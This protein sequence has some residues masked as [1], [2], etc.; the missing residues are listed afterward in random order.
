MISTVQKSLHKERLFST[1]VFHFV[2]ATAMEEY[3]R[4]D[5]TEGGEF[6]FTAIW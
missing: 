1:S 2:I 4:F 3:N 6:D 5:S